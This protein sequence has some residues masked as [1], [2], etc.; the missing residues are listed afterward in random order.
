MCAEGG[1][2]SYHKGIIVDPVNL[3]QCVGE[4][5]RVDGGFSRAIDRKL[6]GKCF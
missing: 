3:I 1:I 5:Y 2:H 6:P 4:I